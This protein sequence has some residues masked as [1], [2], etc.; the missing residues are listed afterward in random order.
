MGCD[1]K[2]LTLWED[3][4]ERNESRSSVSAELQTPT[5]GTANTS[6]SCSKQG[7]LTPQGLLPP[8]VWPSAHAVTLQ[9]IGAPRGHQAGHSESDAHSQSHHEI[10]N[11]QKSLRIA[12]QGFSRCSRF[13]KS[14]PVSCLFSNKIFNAVLIA[15]SSLKKGLLFRL[16]V[17][18][19]DGM[20][21]S[22]RICNKSDLG[23]PNPLPQQP[24]TKANAF[25][26]PEATSGLE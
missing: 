1:K 10:L 4:K 11:T 17:N 20:T 25:F 22:S 19:V 9:W 2:G 16:E 13:S 26:S 7:P 23:E 15:H 3:G 21:P 5:P 6:C 8:D 18:N 14:S 12:Q 24:Y